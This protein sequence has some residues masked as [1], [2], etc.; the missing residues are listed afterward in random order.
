MVL[1]FVN[2]EGETFG[3]AYNK[4]LLKVYDEGIVSEKESY[5]YKTEK[6]RLF[7]ECESRF[8]IKNALEEPLLSKAM[9]GL[10]NFPDYIADILLGRKDHLVKEGVYTYTYSERINIPEIRG[11]Q[12]ASV[13]ERLGKHPFSNR[14][15]VVIWRVPK[16]NLMDSGQPC[17]QRIWLKVYGNA[18]VEHTDWRSRDLTYAYDQNVIGMLGIGYLVILCLNDYYDLGLKRL[19]YVDRCDSLHVYEKDRNYFER[20][21][22]LVRET[23]RKCLLKSTDRMT[24]SL[25]QKDLFEVVETAKKK[26]FDPIFS[27]PCG[28]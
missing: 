17:L 22:N 15:Q 25:L 13:I 16:D 7:R 4:L 18:L 9:P 27:A 28:I 8:V 21:V 11:G 1:P 26:I 20:N 24:R 5:A 14:A 6:D 10:P 3:E 12:L 23:G 19:Y 2:V